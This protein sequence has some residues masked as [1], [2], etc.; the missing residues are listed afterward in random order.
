[1]HPSSREIGGALANRTPPPAA[2]PS[3]TSSSDDGSVSISQ[4][5]TVH[6]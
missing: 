6:C 5:T 3:E 2:M 1:M 4:A